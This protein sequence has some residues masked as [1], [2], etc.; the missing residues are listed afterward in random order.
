VVKPIEQQLRNLE[1]RKA[2]L[3]EF[4]VYERAVDQDTYGKMFDKLAQTSV[5]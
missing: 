1:A 3:V 5:T 2:R 4:Y